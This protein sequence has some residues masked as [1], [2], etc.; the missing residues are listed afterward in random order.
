M[1]LFL[2]VVIFSAAVYCVCSAEL[3]YFWHMS[4]THM[5]S[6]YKQGS[7]V[8]DGCY[9]GKG[10]AGKFGDYQCRSP[11]T[12]EDTAMAT[13]PSLRPD[14]CKDKRPLFVLWTG[15]AGARRFGQFSKDVIEWEMKNITVELA[16]LQKALGGDVPIFPVIGNHDSY[17]QHQFPATDYWVYTVAEE[18]WRQFLPEE[19]RATLKKGGYYTV[20]ITDGLR[21]IVLNTVIYYYQNKMINPSTKDPGGQ[22]AWLRNQL[23]QAEINKESVYIASH[24]PPGVT[25]DPMH[26]EFIKPFLD[27]MKGYHHVIRGSFWGHLHL[28]KF[29]LLGN[30]S[31]G[32]TDFHVAHLASTLGSKTEKDPSFRRYIFDSSKSFAIQDWT[33]YHMHLP[34]A[35]KKGKIEWKYL[36]SAKSSYSIE[37]ATPASM[38][39]LVNKLKTDDK[40]FKTLYHYQKGGAS[41]GSCEGKCKKEFICLLL[42]A[43]PAE[44]KKCIE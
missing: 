6:D 42:H 12:V 23:A 27:G 3:G 44:Y 41:M 7:S 10:N 17:P 25:S 11:F 39:K 24:I 32:S 37:D 1:N 18:C 26:T 2:R 15:D 22:I 20:K 16:K 13:I 38:L 34:D 43:Y 33:T 9:S 14:S 4:D 36:Y 40:L 35:N 5:Q 19:A 31:S 29:M 8:K 28:D 30:T 21:L